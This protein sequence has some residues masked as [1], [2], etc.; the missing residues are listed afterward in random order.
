MSDIRKECIEWMKV[1]PSNK[2][3][4]YPDEYKKFLNCCKNMWYDNPQD[5]LKWVEGV[6]E[7]KKRNKICLMKKSETKWRHVH[8]VSTLL[9]MVQFVLDLSELLFIVMSGVVI[10][11]TG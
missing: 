11:L 3:D 5:M 7:R 2:R 9:E 8:G 10:L 6:W 1:T 4:N